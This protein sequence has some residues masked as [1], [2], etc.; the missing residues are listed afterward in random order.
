[1]LDAFVETYLGQANGLFQGFLLNGLLAL[2]GPFFLWGG[3]ALVLGRLGAA[4]PR[5]LQFL[6]GRTPLVSDIRRGLKGSSSA[7]SVNRLAVIMILTMSVITLAARSKGT[8][9][10]WWMSVRQR[11]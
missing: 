11:R 5:I 3:G 4:G 2:F 10:P 8:L 1:M 9:G 6:F 7:E